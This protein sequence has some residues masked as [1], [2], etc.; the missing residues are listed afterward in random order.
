MFFKG[1]GFWLAPPSSSSTLGIHAAQV[2]FFFF[3]EEKPDAPS[4]PVSEKN[5]LPRLQPFFP[6][7][8]S[9]QLWRFRRARSRAA[10]TIGWPFGEGPGRDLS[11]EHDNHSGGTPRSCTEDA[12]PASLYQPAV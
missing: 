3:T 2:G 5:N 10:G 7:A 12:E 9:L 4:A 6:N 11:R 1:W 8:I